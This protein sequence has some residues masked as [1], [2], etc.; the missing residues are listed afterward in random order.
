MENIVQS[1]NQLRDDNDIGST[2]FDISLDDDF[3]YTIFPKFKALTNMH[4][5]NFRE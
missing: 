1:F 2:T 5:S 4:L 3:K